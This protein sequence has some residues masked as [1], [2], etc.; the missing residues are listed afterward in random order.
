M[1]KKLFFCNE[2]HRETRH[3][4]I[5]E[6]AQVSLTSDK[7]GDEEKIDEDNMLYIVECL[8][9]GERSF[10]SMWVDYFED[11]A[12]EYHYMQYPTPAKRFRPEWFYLDLAFENSDVFRIFSETLRAFDEGLNTLA[13]QGARTTFDL[14]ASDLLNLKTRK[15]FGDKLNAL[16][17]AGYITKDE[18]VHIYDSIVQFGNAASHTTF[19][20]TPENLDRVLDILQNI[21]YRHYIMGVH[22]QRASSDLDE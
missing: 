13:A 4:Y 3:K 6:A 20:P 11:E 17:K 7:N 5:A 16:A 10:V 8:G 22:A 21:I 12:P 14:V 15:N 18:N 1:A 19:R 9:C 2:C